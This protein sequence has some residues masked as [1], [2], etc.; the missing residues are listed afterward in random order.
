MKITTK[1]LSS[2]ILFLIIFFI[3]F[4]LLWKNNTNSLSLI[5]ENRINEY[6]IS[7]EST[8]NLIDKPYRN[9]NFNNSGWDD[10][11]SFVYQPD[12][13]WADDNLKSSME[14]LDFEY[15]GVINSSK[16]VLYYTQLTNQT[17]SLENK[18]KNISLDMNNPT[19]YEMVLTF[20]T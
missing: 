1:L 7:F 2:L 5:K 10:L 13:A 12:K 20:L 18:I 14:T 4:V 6:K 15:M 16:E 8:I 3:I 17:L 11:V 9:I 19:F